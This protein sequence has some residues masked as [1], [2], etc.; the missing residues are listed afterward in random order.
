M[1]YIYAEKDLGKSGDIFDAGAAKMS[2]A[3]WSK[4]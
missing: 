2:S 4:F 1:V 3:G